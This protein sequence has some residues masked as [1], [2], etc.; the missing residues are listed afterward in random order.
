MAAMTPQQQSWRKCALALCMATHDRLG[1]S[2]SQALRAVAASRDLMV[3]IMWNV[4]P[5]DAPLVVKVEYICERLKI[6]ADQPLMEIVARAT[7][8][9]Q[10]TTDYQG[11]PLV[12]K[13][14]GI[15]DS[16]LDRTSQ[17]RPPSTPDLLELKADVHAAMIAQGEKAWRAMQE[18]R[19]NAVVTDHSGAASNAAAAA[20]SHVVSSVGS[21]ER[22]R[23]WLREHCVSFP[24]HASLAELEAL[25]EEERAA[26]A[27]EE[28]AMAQYN[29]SMESRGQPTVVT[30]VSASGANRTVLDE[31][32]AGEE[33]ARRELMEA[34]READALAAI[35]VAIGSEV[36]P[37]DPLSRASTVGGAVP[38]VAAAAV[39]VDDCSARRPK[40]GVAALM[41]TLR[42]S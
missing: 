40:G 30:A 13:V 10:L 38:V 28:A 2:C 25:V 5:Y 7:D 23:K 34:A 22:L 39:A 21:A 33:Q 36:V 4:F 1:A 20:G 35:P 41:N 16:L 14:D 12:L 32:R 8:K 27:E 18:A 11:L 26:I 42:I 15:L 37:S 6:N 31:A 3:T 24:V 19:K 29:A 9:L 17:A